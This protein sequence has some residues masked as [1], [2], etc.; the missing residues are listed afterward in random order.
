MKAIFCSECGQSC[1]P[2]AKFCHACGS[3]LVK[4]FSAE[5]ADPVVQN[6][7]WTD[8][9]YQH[10]YAQ[11]GSEAE[12]LVRVHLTQ[13]PIDAS[14]YALL[15]ASLM[16]QY[17]VADAGEAFDRAIALDHDN[18]IVCWEYAVYLARLGRYTDA[19]SEAQHAM[20]IAPTRDD[21]DRAREAW[22]TLTQKSHGAF[23][24]QSSLPSF[25]WLS[26]LFNA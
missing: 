25:Q 24:H 14:A 18:F 17:N 2:T 3:Q 20:Q 21:F 26:R 19:T 12:K 15:G 22:R 1:P 11:E 4:N 13:E 9:V 10:L 8:E 23:A 16:A 6:P 7:P 5:A